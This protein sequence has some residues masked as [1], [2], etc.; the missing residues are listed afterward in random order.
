M[1]TLS[2]KTDY[3]LIALS[4]LAEQ[5]GR[6][7]SAREIA[8]AYNMPAALLMNLLK[9]LNQHKILRSSRGTNGGYQLAVDLHKVSLYEIIRITDGDVH[10]T[11][12]SC[13][14]EVPSGCRVAVNC[15]IQSPLKA[16]HH[17]MIRF[18]R[19]V[20]LSDLILPGHR[21]DVPLE[22]VGVS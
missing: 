2:K 5:S 21:I 6:I 4:Y 3:A 22:L 16:F 13:E 20:K 12:C 11:E 18:L 17:K 1:L 14:T 19:D 8:K 7:A 15:P 10:T 9:E